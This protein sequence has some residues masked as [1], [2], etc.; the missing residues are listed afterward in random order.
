MLSLLLFPGLGQLAA[1][2]T[3]RGWLFIGVSCLLLMLLVG[4]LFGTLYGT[5]LHD[6]ERDVLNMNGLHIMSLLS[7]A[8]TRAGELKGMVWARTKLLS[9][10]LIMVWLGSAIDAWFVTNRSGTTRDENTGITVHA[11]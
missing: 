3:R 5:V 6:I 1:G 2:H 9:I 4:L 8:S 11:E 7:Y 10:L